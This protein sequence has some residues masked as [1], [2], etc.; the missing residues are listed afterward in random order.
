[1]LVDG[2]WFFPES[3][4]RGASEFEPGAS[5][6]CPQG[7]P[8]SH[9][10]NN[11]A[12]N[13]GKYGLRIFT[14]R[15]HNGE[16]LPGFYPRTLDACAPV[17]ATNTF[18]PAEFKGQFS[19]RNGH[20]GITFGSVAA[21]RI[22]DAVV[23]D[24]VMRGVEGLGADGVVNGVGSSITKL[25]GWGWG[26]NKLVRPVFIGHAQE[27][28]PACDHSWSPLFA[29]VDKPARFGSFGPSGHVRLGLM[30]PAWWGL[31]VENATFI[32][33]DR[34][35]MIAVAG[36][37]KAFPPGAGYDFYANGGMETRFVGTK[38]VESAH[39]RVRFRWDEE[40][41][42]TDVDGTF[43]EQAFCAGCHVMRSALL[44]SQDAF[45]DCF[46]DARYHGHVCKPN[47]HFVNVGFWVKP[48]TPPA[49]NPPIRLSYRNDKG[50]YV[51]PDDIPYLTN[52]W[53]PEGAFNLVD[54]DI[55][56]NQLQMKIVGEHDS[57]YQPNWDSA[58]AVWVSKHRLRADFT[59]VDQFDNF[60]KTANGFEGVISEDGTTLTWLPRPWDSNYS[61]AAIQAEL[62][63]AATA[64]AQVRAP[65]D[66]CQSNEPPS[67]Q[68]VQV[69]PHRHYEE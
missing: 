23:A 12:H 55:S 45:P 63:A 56:T 51:Q 42:L 31:T 3:K 25:R 49:I 37:S 7:V 30:N 62:A 60:P 53:R 21:L 32:Q 69:W 34:D 27:N 9:H 22:I 10:N 40:M 2:F 36:F 16:G 41:L 6:V 57:G 38:W 18:A 65:C 58:T 67:S 47:Y 14:G 64:L 44:V 26:A 33:Y 50:A 20:N 11:E 8:I 48:V 29:T 39:H 52:K 13:N 54:F 68:R 1:M 61:P 19:W 24:N 46:Y 28:C 5:Q 59:Y 66:S 15:N 43:T 35:G 17:S 4:V